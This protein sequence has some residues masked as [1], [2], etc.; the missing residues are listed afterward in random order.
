MPGQLTNFARARCQN[1]LAQ[2]ILCIVDAKARSRQQPYTATNDIQSHRINLLY[3]SVHMLA[4][5]MPA[6]AHYELE[7]SFHF[8]RC[9]FLES[10]IRI[11]NGDGGFFAFICSPFVFVARLRARCF[12]ISLFCADGCCC[13]GGFFYYCVVLIRA[14]TH[15]NTRRGKMY[16]RSTRTGDY[17]RHTKRNE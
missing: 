12:S 4:P 13:C 5:Y 7:T 16:T 2:L 3:G 1:R 11:L 9:R 10:E 15:T 17:T 8:I 6:R 14:Q